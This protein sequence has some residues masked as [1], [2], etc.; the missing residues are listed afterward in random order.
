M[1]RIVAIIEV[2]GAFPTPRRAASQCKHVTQT[3]VRY[4]EL[5]CIGLEC[6]GLEC[7]GFECIGLECIG[8]E[9]IGLECIGFECIELANCL[10]T[11][12]LHSTRSTIHYEPNASFND[13]V[14]L[15]AGSV[16]RL[17]VDAIVNAANSLLLS[18]GGGRVCTSR[19]LCI[20]A[21]D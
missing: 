15:F 14:S 13:K 11:E 6:I 8:L 19:R 1:E 17:Q 3:L 21:D 2:A 4:V 5:E 20:V 18:G 12:K 7:I 9:C 16:T 10:C